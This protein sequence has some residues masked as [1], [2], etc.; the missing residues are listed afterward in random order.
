MESFRV[1]E[2]GAIGLLYE[3]DQLPFDLPPNGWNFA[4]NVRFHNGDA[5]AARGWLKR[6]T[7][8][9]PCKQLT[10][11]TGINGNY[12]I[13]L[14]STSI[15]SIQDAFLVADVTRGAS[16]VK[17]NYTSDAWHTHS[18]Q[19]VPIATNGVN[20]PQVQF[21][22]GQAPGALTEF[23]DLPNWPTTDRCNLLVGYKNFM[24]ALNLTENGNNYPTKITWS[25]AAAPGDLP[26]SWDVDDPTT[27]A[28]SLV[29]PADTGPIVAAEVLRD[30]L[31]IYTT[32]AVHRLTFVGGAYVM[33][34]REITKNFGAFGPHSVLHARGQHI[35]L[36]RDDLIAFDG[37]QGRSIAQARARRILQNAIT[38]AERGAARIAYNSA[39]NEIWFGMVFPL[40]K[41][42]FTTFNVA[43]FDD[44]A[45]A[46][47][48]A[49]SLVDFAE[50][51]DR[52]S[53]DR[54]A[55][56]AYAWDQIA[57]LPDIDGWDK[58]GD[59]SWDT[60]AQKGSPD[61]Y[62]VM[63]LGS[64]GS[65]YRMDYGY[66]F[67]PYTEYETRLEKTDLNITGDEN[68]AVVLAAYP[69][70]TTEQLLQ[71]PPV[72]TWDEIGTK[73]TFWDGSDGGDPDYS[74][75]AWDQ[76]F[77]GRIPPS[78][79]VGSQQAAGEAVN[80]REGKKLEGQRKVT[81]KARGVRHGLKIVS[82]GHP[83]RLSGYDLEYE[84]SGR[85]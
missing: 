62:Y 49:P 6:F 74:A 46:Q 34:R 32:N 69:R 61:D 14:G 85:R 64:D 45:I 33:Q 19:G 73:G 8:D 70:F 28:A 9:E 59:M 15:Y 5:E 26:S 55:F 17:V 7:L 25:D 16:T 27:L 42:F 41:G 63:G 36:T 50:L 67:Q 65:V 23:I 78:L 56:G 43:G 75:Y 3:T 30:D 58:V 51:P 72:R 82:Q 37:N 57:Q 80:W 2:P 53:T 22:A 48:Q 54:V 79:Y 11:N 12:W 71:T 60:S 47:R 35:V 1:T 10:Y 77:D 21:V 84:P 31:I 20:L 76:F 13:A 81:C 52:E 24:V 44:G 39:F 40:Q 83:W 68:A 18:F 4:Y 38:A 66:E 29:L